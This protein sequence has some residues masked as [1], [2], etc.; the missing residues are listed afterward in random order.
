MLIAV[1]DHL[2]QARASRGQVPL[3]FLVVIGEWLELGQLVFELPVNFGEFGDPLG[4]FANMQ[5]R[6]VN[7]FALCMC[8]FGRMEPGLAG[9][10]LTLAEVP[11][12]TA[13]EV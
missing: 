2:T 7:C 13:P 8:A 6:A 4:Q 11:A 9:P 5:V 1:P 10:M 3:K 12:E